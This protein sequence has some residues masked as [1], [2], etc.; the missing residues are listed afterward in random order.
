MSKKNILTC[1]AAILAFLV[2]T[3]T[4]ALYRQD[5]ND[6]VV[7]ITFGEIYELSIGGGES[8]QSTKINPDNPTGS[9]NV[10]LNNEKVN[11]DGTN[12]QYT[13]GKFY[14]EIIGEGQ[15]LADMLA[16]SA[17]QGGVEVASHD[18]LVKPATS[19]PKGYVV[20]LGSNPVLLE[21]TYTLSDA[22]KT[23]YLDYAGQSVKVVF[24]WEFTEEPS[25]TINVY[26]RWG[27]NNINYY[28]DGDLSNREGTIS[29]F[30]N[31]V[32]AVITVPASVQSI[33]F[34]DASNN[35]SNE[36][37]PIVVDLS[38]VTAKEVWTLFGEKEED[39]AEVYDINPEKRQ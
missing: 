3:T 33:T 19:E 27:C 38:K 14:V 36:S 24:H 31:D 2:L 32:W 29:N 6:K 5:A 13:Y 28:F 20:K 15:G 9:I 37:T 16:F 7:S 22:A 12:D 21:V 4:Y 1:V 23:N 35:E 18:I 30:V 17:K 39:F 34:K 10:E 25:R 26:N 8:P 11:S